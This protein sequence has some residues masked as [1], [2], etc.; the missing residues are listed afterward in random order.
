MKPYALNCGGAKEMQT[1][2]AVKLAQQ[3]L[4]NKLNTAQCVVDATAGN[5]KDTLFLAKYSCDNVIIWAF[6]IQQVAILKTKQL[7]DIHNL[8]NK[9]NLVVDSHINITSYINMQIDVAM[10]NLGYLPNS[11]HSIA[12]EYHSTIVALQQVLSLLSVGG[13]VSLVA[14]PGHE[15]GYYEQQAVQEFLGSLPAKLFTVGCWSMINHVNNSPILYIVEKVRSEAC[16]SF[17]SRQY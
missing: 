8:T 11:E 7:L 2:S 10:F 9:V 17:A 3:L 14:Y 15:Q 13:V 5:G 6:D 1:F 4:I 12:T 16:E